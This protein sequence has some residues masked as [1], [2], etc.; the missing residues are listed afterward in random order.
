M[1]RK[2]RAIVENRSRGSS[3]ASRG[4]FSDAG[5]ANDPGTWNHSDAGYESGARQS[6]SS[7]G[8]R[9]GNKAIQEQF[10]M[11]NHFTKKQ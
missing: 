7:V 1:S 3:I 4:N 10:L 6:E 11:R 8:N 2:S 9:R 5:S